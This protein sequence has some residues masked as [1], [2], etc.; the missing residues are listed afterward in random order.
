MFTEP[1]LIKGFIRHIAPSLRLFVSNN[2]Q[3]YLHFFYSAGCACDVCDH[4]HL[5]PRGSVFTVFTLQ[6]LPLLL[7][8]GRSSRAVLSQG[9]SRSRFITIIFLRSVW[10]ELPLPRVA[11]VPTSPALTPH[12][13]LSSRRGADPST[14]FWRSFSAFEWKSRL[15]LTCETQL[16]RLSVSLMKY[17]LASQTW[18]VAPVS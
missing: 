4:S 11:S 9:A 10:A 8:Y 12:S 3:A 5:P 15:F 18:L 17:L 16:V 2:L 1:S 14:M 13:L 7:S 6:L